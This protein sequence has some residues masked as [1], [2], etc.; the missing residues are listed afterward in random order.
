LRDIVEDL[1]A[2]NTSLV[3]ITPQLCEKSR[4]MVEKHKLNFPLLRDESN[5]YTDEL[6]VRIVVPNDVLEVY[7]NFGIDIPG[8]NGEDSKT[9]PI[10]YRLVINQQG[11]VQFADIDPNYTAR[12]EPSKTLTDVRTMLG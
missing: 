12:P 1:N 8:A 10:P 6:G 5:Q 7:G 4:E 9:L 11:I 2:L 3:A